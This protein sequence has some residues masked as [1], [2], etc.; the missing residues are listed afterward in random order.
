QV[1]LVARYN[2]EESPSRELVELCKTK[3]LH[4]NNH[5]QMMM[6]RDQLEEMRDAYKKKVD[7]SDKRIQ[8]KRTNMMFEFNRATFYRRLGGDV[9]EI[10]ENIDLDEVTDFWRQMWTADEDVTGHEE[11][12]E[13]LD[14]VTLQADTSRERIAAEVE[15]QV[16]FLANWK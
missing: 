8:F 6:L 16:R 10:D 13:L 11:M 7:I 4:T 5:E 1:E 12:L 3:G 2:K 9:N 14:P 15:R